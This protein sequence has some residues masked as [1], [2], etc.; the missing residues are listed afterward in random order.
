MRGSM[1][2]LSCLL[3]ALFLALTLP[4]SA[5]AGEIAYDAVDCAPFFQ[6]GA[7][8]GPQSPLH[9]G[10]TL[11]FGG[12]DLEARIL[13]CMAGVDA[14]AI[15][16]EYK[17]FDYGGGNIET[18]W[19]VLM[20]IADL[21]Y[22]YTQESLNTINSTYVGA[23]NSNP[24]YFYFDSGF[25]ISIS[26]GIITQLYLDINHDFFEDIDAFDAEL[27]RMEEEA[28]PADVRG[29]LTDTQKALAVHD[30]LALNLRY[31]YDALSL[32][33]TDTNFLAAHSAYGP[34]VN[35]KAVCQGYALCYV[36]MMQDLGVGACYVGSTANHHAW[37]MVVT[38]AGAYHVDVT[39][40]DPG[41]GQTSMNV[42][43]DNDWR[44]YV[45]HSFFLLTDDEIQNDD[46]HDAWDDVTLTSAL[47]AHPNSGFWSGVESGMFYCA[48][49]WYYLDSGGTHPFD[50]YDPDY[51][52]S[53]GNLCRT[54]Y[55]TGRTATQLATDTSLPAY[56]NQRIFY[57]TVDDGPVSTLY[58]YDVVH[59]ETFQIG[60]ADISAGE[61]LTEM[62]VQN[63]QL[64]YLAVD[65]G[66]DTWELR[67]YALALDAHY[68]DLDQDGS[69]TADDLM[70]LMRHVIGTSVL[71][72]PALLRADVNG[73]GRVTLTDTAFLCR[74]LNGSISAFPAE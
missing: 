67:T 48:G 70:D 73:D 20:E 40:D 52:S 6:E 56:W 25:S 50:W 45:S 9:S 33:E 28:V 69:V 30:Y 13:T 15:V 44:G 23:V 53:M 4:A 41:W 2:R 34:V 17:T 39:F 27:A 54:P 37:N 31:D 74:Y 68:G 8:E 57:Y 59:D 3:L 32:P 72:D 21:A 46:D 26:G 42:D 24:Q 60:D 7:F 18:K 43:G 51:A 63:E 71:T 38:E 16:P 29:T 11:F 12:D 14:G 36:V 10:A 1:K 65:P 22:P 62:S 5:L 58:A 19:V 61:L 35:K 49:N 47:T 55:G 64:R 66:D